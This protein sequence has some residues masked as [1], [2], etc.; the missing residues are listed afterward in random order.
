MKLESYWRNF[1]RKLKRAILKFSYVSC[2]NSILFHIHLLNVVSIDLATYKI[3]LNLLHEEINAVDKDA[4]VNY[5]MVFGAIEAYKLNPDPTM[6][7]ADQCYSPWKMCYAKINEIKINNFVD[8]PAFTG[9]SSDDYCNEIQHYITKTLSSL[10]CKTLLHLLSLHR[11]YN[12]DV[13]VVLPLCGEST[14]RCTRKR[15]NDNSDSVGKKKLRASKS[16]SVNR[17]KES[18][19]ENV[20]FKLPKN[21]YEVND[22]WIGIGK[23][24]AFVKQTHGLNLFHK[25][26]S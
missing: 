19:F 14:V 7:A 2:K 8:F 3:F 1:Y 21:Y 23:I 25:F 16:D 9:G 13:D 24:I 20:L 26:S 17:A 18:F 4:S 5:F 11:R 15:L 22:A 6:I 12:S 10:S